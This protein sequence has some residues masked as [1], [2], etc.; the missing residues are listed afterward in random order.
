M[1]IMSETIHLPKTAIPLPMDE[2]VAFCKRW[3]IIR[4]ELFG[5]ILRD[6]FDPT[7]SD[8]DFLVT[9]DPKKR[10]GLFNIEMM[11]YELADLLNREI[12]FVER[13]VIENDSNPYL[14]RSL[15]ESTQLLYER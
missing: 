13:P 12:D 3:N 5:S 9:F 14:R 15:L 10:H 6:D 8:I 4:L 1:V 11:R 2:I 7:R